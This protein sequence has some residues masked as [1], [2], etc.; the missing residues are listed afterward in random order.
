MTATLPGITIRRL[1]A[2]H[3]FTRAGHDNGS[4]VTDYIPAVRDYEVGF[5]PDENDVVPL[6]LEQV[7][8]GGT[9]PGIV[10]FVRWR[11]EVSYSGEGRLRFWDS[12]DK[13]NEL[14]PSGEWQ[15]TPSNK[16][17][18]Q[19]QGSV[20]AVHLE[21]MEPSSEMG[22]I[23]VSF[24]VETQFVGGVTQVTQFKQNKVTVTPVVNS[25]T[26]TEFV[27]PRYSNWRDVNHPWGDGTAPWIQG[28]IYFR[29]EYVRPSDG[30]L[31]FVQNM[32]GWSQDL[33]GNVAATSGDS[34]DPDF[35]QFQWR[36]RPDLIAPPVPS[37]NT[38][39]PLN[40][41]AAVG[42]PGDPEPFYKAESR[43]QTPGAPERSWFMEAI[44]HPRIAPGNGAVKLHSINFR[45]S[46]RT[47]VVWGKMERGQ[48]IV[49]EIQQITWWMKFDFSVY[50]HAQQKFLQN[51]SDGGAM[52]PVKAA[53]NAEL[54]RYYFNELARLDP[55]PAPA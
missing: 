51:F 16:P 32:R 45:W 17:G 52:Q 8:P 43:A 15:F 25:F 40:D 18:L 13:R 1:K 36:L 29:V 47:F 44:D 49:K 31:Y 11:L 41:R 37:A 6:I 53:V 34:G 9:Y 3:S 7:P 28:E 12:P 10:E 26:V 33:P 55:K 2:S 21:G 50:N 24:A 27:K 35:K 30:D 5:T 54:R 39:F 38:E 22:D 14:I 42:G 20:P 19:G 4:L 48:L 23:I 46:F